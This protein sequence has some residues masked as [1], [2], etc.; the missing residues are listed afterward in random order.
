MN[1]NVFVSVVGL[2]VEKQIT[3][4]F[5]KHRRKIVGVPFGNLV[6]GGGIVLVKFFGEPINRLP[7]DNITERLEIR[8]ID[9]NFFMNR[10]KLFKRRER[11]NRSEVLRLVMKSNCNAALNIDALKIFAGVGRVVQNFQMRVVQHSLIK[12]FR[13]GS[14]IEEKPRRRYKFDFLADLIRRF[15]KLIVNGRCKVS[16]FS[17]R[18]FLIGRVADNKIKFHVVASQKNFVAG[19]PIN[20]VVKKRNLHG[21]RLQNV[22]LPKIFT[23]NVRNLLQVVLRKILCEFGERQQ[24]ICAGD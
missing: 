10:I 11:A 12:I 6:D 23:D 21:R 9:T 22:G 15:H 18:I 20:R 14:R 1:L 7:E 24:N 19:M 16:A 5:H 2:F 17:F 13:R 8:I 3:E 4:P